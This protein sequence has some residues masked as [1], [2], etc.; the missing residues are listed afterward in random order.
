MGRSWHYIVVA[1]S[2]TGILSRYFHGKTEEDHGAYNGALNFD[3]VQYWTSTSRQKQVTY[4]NFFL[5]E[6]NIGRHRHPKCTSFWGTIWTSFPD[7]AGHGWLAGHCGG[8]PYKKTLLY[9]VTRDVEMT[10]IAVSSYP[11]TYTL[12]G[13]YKERNIVK[14]FRPRQ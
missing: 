10:N 9:C 6:N 13:R 12:T 14:S 8:R 7:V 4:R 1:Q 11:M 3:S 2:G 5:A